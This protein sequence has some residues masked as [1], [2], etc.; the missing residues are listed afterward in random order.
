MEKVKKQ[1]RVII[2]IL[3]LFT[4]SGE[5]EKKVEISSMSKPEIMLV[6][7]RVISSYDVLSGMSE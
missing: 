2:R 3:S 7:G 5:G 6:D 1:Y 4:G